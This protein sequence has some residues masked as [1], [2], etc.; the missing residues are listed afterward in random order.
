AQ[1]ASGVDEIH[2]ATSPLEPRREDD[3]LAPGLGVAFDPPQRTREAELDHVA[4]E[5]AAEDRE[6]AHEPEE[7]SHT[8]CNLIAKIGPECRP[9]RSLRRPCGRCGRDEVPRSRER[10]ARVRA[11]RRATLPPAR[12]R[13]PLAGRGR[14]RSGWSRGGVAS[15]PWRETHRGSPA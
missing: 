12:R 1:Q 14:A 4:R 15:G 7:E 5:D 9:W 3:P 10:T 13:A 6:G 8:A 2:L 11:R